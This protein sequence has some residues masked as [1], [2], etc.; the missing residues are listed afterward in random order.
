MEPNLAITIVINYNRPP[1]P[2]AYFFFKSFHSVH[3]VFFQSGPQVFLF[4]PSTAYIAMFVKFQCCAYSLSNGLC[5]FYGQD[6]TPENELLNEAKIDALYEIELCYI[7]NIPSGPFLV[8]TGQIKYF[9]FRYNKYRRS[10][11]SSSSTS[12]I[13][14]DEDITKANNQVIR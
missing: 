7:N 1:H 5:V 9:P 4:S 6:I 8:S 14:I 11:E 13:T 10:T 3:S 2:H 12:T